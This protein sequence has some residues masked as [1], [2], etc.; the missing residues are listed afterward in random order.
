MNSNLQTFIDSIDADAYDYIIELSNAFYIDN[1]NKELTNSQLQYIAY[2]TN[3]YF[4]TEYTDD[5]HIVARKQ[6]LMTSLISFMN[7]LKL[8]KL[9]LPVMY[10]Y[11]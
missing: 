4:D 11:Q 5:D 9:D 3:K 10:D 2:K 8:S 7:S 6:S 1:N